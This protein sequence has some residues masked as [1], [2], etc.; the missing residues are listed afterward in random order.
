[1]AENFQAKNEQVLQEKLNFGVIKLS[2]SLSMGLNTISPPRAIGKLRPTDRT[3]DK[4]N[5]IYIMHIS[6]Y[7]SRIFFCM[8]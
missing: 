1:M 6:I 5:M 3:N 4:L 7:L 2:L 8:P